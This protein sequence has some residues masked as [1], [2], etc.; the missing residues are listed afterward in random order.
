MD[1]QTELVIEEVRDTITALN[2]DEVRKPLTDF[3][4]K[5]KERIEGFRV[6]IRDLEF[7]RS[8]NY[9]II[10][11]S[12]TATKAILE[13]DKSYKDV[14]DWGG[15]KMTA[16][17]EYK[18]SNEHLCQVQYGFIVREEEQDELEKLRKEKEE[19]EKKE[20]EQQIIRETE[21]NTR[22][23]ER[24]K[25]ERVAK[26]AEQENY[27]LEA[28]KKAAEQAK[29]NAEN[30]AKEA[31]IIAEQERKRAEIQANL[32]KEAALK[33][34][35]EKF[36]LKKEAEI[37]AAKAREEDVKHRTKINN[38]AANAMADVIDKDKVGEMIRGYNYIRGVP[39]LYAKRILIAIAKGKI[40]HVSIKY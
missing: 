1:K 37:E 30:R 34:E 24:E 38:E 17:I 6:K 23:V 20:R 3:E 14:S 11:D 15:F 39:L 13:L 27:R 21:E 5:E 22:R 8:A 35:R 16:D 33:K 40:P 25:A 29:V 31:A 18:K 10:V 32:D 4:D 28:E 9:N 26:E 2:S 7:Y 19:R 36:R 12:E